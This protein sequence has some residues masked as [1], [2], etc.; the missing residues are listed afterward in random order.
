MI[1]PNGPGAWFRRASGLS[2]LKVE[3][4][5]GMEPDYKTMF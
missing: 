1:D 5:E 4:K 2:V 3:R